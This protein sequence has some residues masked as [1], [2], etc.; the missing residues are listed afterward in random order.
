MICTVSKWG[1]VL[2][3][4]TNNKRVLSCF[5]VAA[6]FKCWFPLNEWLFKMAKHLENAQCIYDFSKAN[7]AG[8]L[9]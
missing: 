6:I 4:Y 2:D 8:I 9:K 5:S 7:F 3:K 1:D